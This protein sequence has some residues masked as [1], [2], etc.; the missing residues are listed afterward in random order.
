LGFQGSANPFLDQTW[1]GQSQ[2]YFSMT[3]SVCENGFTFTPQE[4]ILMK[5]IKLFVLLIYM[6][7]VT[8]EAQ[9]QDPGSVSLIFQFV[10]VIFTFIVFYF[11]RII[12]FLSTILIKLRKEKTDDE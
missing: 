5:N 2:S 11:R 8:A 4:G 6:C 10:L 9:Y 12:G 1:S 3:T 7:P